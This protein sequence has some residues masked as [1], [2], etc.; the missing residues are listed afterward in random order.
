MAA[1]AV[2][3]QRVF[4]PDKLRI[5]VVDD[6]KVVRKAFARILGEEYDLVEAEDGEG[7]WEILNQDDRIC[8]VFTDLNMPH[9]DG[10]GLLERI[11]RSDDPA[12]SR[13]PVILVTAATDDETESTKAALDAGA[14][15]YVLKP[16]DSVF[17]RSKAKA[18][19]KPRAVAAAGEEDKLATLDPLTRLANRT[20]FFERG[21][22][23]VSAANRHRTE[24]ALLLVAIDDFAE[25]AR[26][27]DDRLLK[28]IIR[29]LGS[30][31][32]SEVRLEDT[33]ARIERDRFAILLSETGLQE[34]AE[35]AERLR[36]KVEGKAIR[37]R[38]SVF[39]VTV[40]I[41]ISAL[42]PTV[43]RT[44]DMLLL[45]AERHLKQARER[46][47]TVVPPPQRAAE[48]LKRMLTTSL[49]EAAAMLNR[50]GEKMSREQA[51][52]T[53]RYLLPLLEHCDQVLGLGLDGVVAELKK[54]IQGARARA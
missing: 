21:A 3:S 29:K 41:G 46:G 9:L 26:Q 18:H 38:D 8:A 22:Q 25:L 35:L 32:S 2:S 40:S 34:A 53:L 23:E 11:R 43:K 31:L 37:H 50:R 16:F 44:F 10:R 51:A 24:L 5:L 28:G 27:I 42:P 47:N 19:V 4:M 15:D 13:L 17:L 48:N 39:R 14:T 54:R 30:Y 33:V 45:D 12:I 36:S 52:V 1:A 6:S 20:Y 49:D 7:A